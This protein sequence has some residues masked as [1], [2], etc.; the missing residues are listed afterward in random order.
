MNL[1]LYRVLTFYKK[2]TLY[3]LQFNHVNL[4]TGH[5][6][7]ILVLN[8]KLASKQ[9]RKQRLTQERKK[10]SDKFTGTDFHQPEL[11][12]SNCRFKKFIHYCSIVQ[13]LFFKGILLSDKDKL[14]CSKN[15]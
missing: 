10:N 9:V 6:F 12:Q 8:L 1:S 2:K 5:I 13:I 15:I 3:D 7:H 14:K 11:I 4:S